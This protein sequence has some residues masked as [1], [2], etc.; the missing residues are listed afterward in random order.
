M[1]RV[2]LA[3]QGKTLA[4]Y[5][6]DAMPVFDGLIAARGRLYMST[7]DGHVVCLGQDIAAGH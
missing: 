3:A 4:E 6:L 7:V 1:L 5:K 2:H